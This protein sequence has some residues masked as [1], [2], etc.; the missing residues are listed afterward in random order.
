MRVRVIVAAIALSL[1]GVSA[2]QHLPRTRT[3][4]GIRPPEPTSLPPQPGPIARAESYQRQRLAVETYP[5][6]SYFQAPGLTGGARPAWTSFGNGAHADYLLSRFASATL[7]VTAS[8]VGGPA[9]TQTAE[10]GTRLRPDLSHERWY[11]YV[12]LR[13]GYMA[14]WNKLWNWPGL[15]QAQGPYGHYNYGFGALAGVGV[16]YSLTRSWSLTT[17]GAV[18]R[19]RMTTSAFDGHRSYPLTAYRYTLGVRYTPVRISTEPAPHP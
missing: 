2:A 9:Q 11:P 5:M 15:D 8:Y 1:P 18:M 13:A 10:L 12:D 3:P 7:D 17:A 6:V 19:G 16:E 14:A 4:E